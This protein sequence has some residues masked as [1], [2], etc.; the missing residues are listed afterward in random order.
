MAKHNRHWFKTKLKHRLE[1]NDKY[2]PIN[3]LK[4]TFRELYHSPWGRFMER[5]EQ[6]VMNGGT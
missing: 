5:L 1:L 3:R 4:C 6:H 2:R